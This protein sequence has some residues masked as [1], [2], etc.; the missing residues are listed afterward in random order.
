MKTNKFIQALVLISTISFSAQAGNTPSNNQQVTNTVDEMKEAQR[1]AREEFEKYKNETVNNY[2]TYKDDVIARYKAYRDSVL[3]EFVKFMNLPWTKTESEPAL[4]K[5]IDK[6]VGP[7][8]IPLKENIQPEPEIVVDNTPVVVPTPAPEPE[9]APIIKEEPKQVIK[10]EPKPKKE[11]PQ[12]SH[13]NNS[14]NKLPVKDVVD[15]SGINVNVQ[16][17]PFV[18]I[19]VPTDNE[20]DYFDFKFFG[21]TMSVRIDDSCIFTLSS[22]NN[23]GIASAMEKITTNETLNITLG[24]CIDLRDGYKLCDWAYLEMLVTLTSSYYG[25]EC[26]EATILAGYLYCMSGYRMR[27]GY[28]GNKVEVLFASDQLITDLPFFSLNSDG[29]RNY[30]TLNSDVSTIKICDY[31]FPNEKNMSLLITDLPEFDEKPTNKNIKLHSYPIRFNYTVNQNLID[32]FDTY[33]TPMT[34][35][36]SYSKWVYYAKVPLSDTAKEQLYPSLK[37]AIAGKSELA[38]VN[39]IMDWIES[40]EYGYDSKVWGY[41]RAFFPD[42]TIYYPSSDCEDHAILFTRIVSD[43]L[44]LKTALIYYPGH[45]AAAVKFN[46]DVR[47][48]YIMHNGEKFTVCDP[49][50]YWRGAGRTMDKMNNAQAIL[51][52]L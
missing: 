27:Y 44:G 9:P 11:K 15:I 23:K 36:D 7:E 40:Y 34:E 20:P 30:Y 42:E 5:P 3:S 51:I 45:L 1:K 4:P 26:N 16:P 38:A 21:T 31:A 14:I 32:F 19:I 39:I 24:D 52:L 22:V 37:Q 43:L 6:S 33:P 8:I 48:D 41:D 35:S 10:E 50:I 25:K 28:H 12:G 18:P 46:G 47:G 13:I 49:T 29:Y 17:V 2:N